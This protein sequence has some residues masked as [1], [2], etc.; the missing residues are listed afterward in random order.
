MTV[1]A[2]IAPTSRAIISGKLIVDTG[3]TLSLLLNSPFVERNKL[4]ADG[5]GQNF[6]VCGFGEAKAIKDKV[7]ALRLGSSKFNNLN[8]IFSQAKSGLNAAD[9]VDGL[10][11]GEILSQYK[12]IF[13]YSRGRMIL[14][15][16]S[17]S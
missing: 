15:S 2:E 17:G 14:E 13:D 8:T 3:F 1:R 4:L 6:M 12:V 16:Y 7:S 5:Q 9:D 11:G 10:L